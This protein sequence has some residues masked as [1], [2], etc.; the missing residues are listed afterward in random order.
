MIWQASAGLRFRM[1]GAYMFAQDGQ[2]VFTLAPNHG[3][4][5]RALYEIWAGKRPTVTTEALHQKLLADLRSW[6]V[7]TVI[8]ATN[9]PNSTQAVTLFTDVVGKPPAYQQDVAVWYGIASG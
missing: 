2:G 7:S 5:E 8:V 9:E 6:H 1:V 4:T 3:V